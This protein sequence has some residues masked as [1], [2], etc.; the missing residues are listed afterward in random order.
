MEAFKGPGTEIR[1]KYIY[2]RS[3]ENRSFAFHLPMIASNEMKKIILSRMELYSTPV[4]Y[5]VMR[6]A[7]D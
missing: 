5:R 4:L 2:P 7:K 3:I 6:F 1:I